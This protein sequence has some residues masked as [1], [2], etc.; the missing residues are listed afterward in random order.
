LLNDFNGLHVIWAI[1]S[2]RIQE[3]SELAPFY[4]LPS[5]LGKRA[6]K[7]LLQ[8]GPGKSGSFAAAGPQSGQGT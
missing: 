3:S 1:G 7:A 4:S 5:A 6:A 2:G 8:G